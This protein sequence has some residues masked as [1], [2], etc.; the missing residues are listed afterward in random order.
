M[1]EGPIGSGLLLGASSHDLG[2]QLESQ[3][4]EAC[5]HRLSDVRWFRTDWQRG[6]AATAYA[7]F[8]SEDRGNL[9]VVV[10]IP[11]G[12][13]EYRF[14]K[15]LSETD[16]PTPRVV[17]HGLEIAGYD[18]GWIV[19]E[20][21]PGNPLAASLHKDVFT[22]LAGA[23]TRFHLRTSELWPTGEA[24]NAFNW[25]VLLEKA[26]A[27]V[28]TNHPSEEQSWASLLK[29]VHRVLPRIV[30]VWDTRAV[31]TWC[32]G[33]LHPGNAMTRPAGTAWGPSDTVLFDLGEVHRGHWVEDAV[34]LERQ[35]WGRPEVL[36]GV[37]PVSLIAKARK[38]VG[39]D[40]SDDYA[41]LANVRRLLMA[42]ISPAFMHREGS[43]RY[44][45]A[46]R[47]VAE[48]MLTAIHA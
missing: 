16:A 13:R 27:S 47:E 4:K 26:R 30:A 33:D 12:P 38:A 3:L 19:M 23:V 28:R 18:L 37:K 10:K 40:C 24:E 9:D 44:L 36:D 2:P 1:T 14:L 21:L 46:A 48:R 6:G 35:F 45:H 29:H 20:R 5:D 15:G 11:V 25:P 7:R 39:M 31:N 17:R 42:S 22:A 8:R 43:P 41:T 34:Y 32:H